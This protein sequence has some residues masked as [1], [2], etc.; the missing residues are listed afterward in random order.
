MARVHS[1][2]T[3]E[4]D[5][6]DEAAEKPY[7]GE[8]YLQ[9]DNVMTSIAGALTL[10]HMYRYYT[11]QEES[12][13]R[14]TRNAS[15]GFYNKPDSKRKDNKCTD[16]RQNENINA[17]Q[18]LFIL[19]IDAPTEET[20]DEIKNTFY[21]EIDRELDEILNRD[22][23]IIISNAN[24]KVGRE[25]IYK[26]VTGDYSK[27]EESNNNEL[28]LTELAIESSTHFQRNDIHKETWI[29]SEKNT[30]N[31]E[32]HVLIQE[33]HSDLITKIRTYRGADSDSDNFLVGV[34]LKQRKTVRR[35]QRQPGNKVQHTRLTRQNK[36]KTICNKDGRKP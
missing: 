24:A 18:N 33:K 17:R 20:E 7:R 28:R 35:R 11:I 9:G 32:N 36:K 25:E 19:N 16:I 1:N 22:T 34:K 13:D 2:L 26:E 14:Q 10:A 12:E 4:T 23:K 6:N 3:R 15:D 29:V 21:E 5:C 30:G 8:E 27:Y 31:T